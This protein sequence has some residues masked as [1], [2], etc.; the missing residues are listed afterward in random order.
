[1]ALQENMRREE[2]RLGRDLAS[3]DGA[4]VIADGPLTFEEA[5]RAA[6]LGYVKRIFR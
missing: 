6:V 5:S 3:I 2:E 1:M 4:M